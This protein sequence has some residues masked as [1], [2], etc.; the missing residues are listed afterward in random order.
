MKKTTLKTC[1]FLVILFLF[2]NLPPVKAQEKDTRETPKIAL[3]LSG[4]GAKGLAHIGV[5]KVL[6]EAGIRPDIITGTSMGSIVGALYAAGYTSDELT[7]INKNA[8]WDQLLTDKVK[9]LS[10]AMDEKQETKKYLF[11]IPVRDNKINLP[12]GLIEGQ[13][14]EAY[15]SELLWPLTS[16][17]NFNQLP[18]PFHCMSVDMISGET[19]EH[20]SGD[21]VQ[22]IRASMSIPTVFSP[23]KMDSLLLVDGGVT[24]NFPVQEAI[25]M[26]ADI[27]IGVY[28]GFQEDVTADEM[29]SMTDILQRSIA[30]AGIVDAKEQFPKCDVLIVPDLG[31]YSAGDFSN[32][33]IIQQLGEE[34]AR[35]K[36][37]E[38]K[39]LATKYNRTFQPLEKIDQPRKIK[40][41][42]FEVDGLQYLSKSYVLSKS[43]LEKGDSVSYKT[44]DEAIDFMY[45]SRHFGK[46]TYSLKEDPEND[47][48][49]LVFQVKENPRAMFKLAPNYDDDLGV[50]IVTNFTLRNMI[51]PATRMLLSFNIAE[52]PG[53]EIMLNKFVGKKQR[54]S[55]YFFASSYSYKL[56]FYDLGK[57]LGNYKRGYFEGGYGLE[58]LFG[59][60]NQIGG[61]AFY[62]YN[63]LTPRADLQSIYPEADFEYLKAHDWGYQ[64]YYKAN[65]TD[66]LYF[67][68]RGIKFN[69]RFQHVL[70]ANSHMK[71]KHFDERD[72]FVKAINEPYATLVLEHNWYK[73]FAKKFTY[74]FGVSGG[75]STE[76][77][78]SNG[79]F[80]LGGSQFGRNKLQFVDFAGFNFAEVYAYNF[81]FLKSAIDWEFATGVHFTA[82]ANVAATANTYEDLVEQIASNP[83]ENSIFG[84]SF[85]FKYES[86]L[87]PMQLMVSG[88]NQDDESRFHFSIGFPF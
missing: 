75:L 16:Q 48:Y 66:D 45:G 1:P 33:A 43:G 31:K 38:I 83:F 12:A 7:E 24:R 55:D 19:I 80:M 68:K 36:F 14:L 61:N 71:L 21:L 63:R 56:P 22:S 52:N 84:Y 6:E 26:G 2:L 81:A 47:G 28:V 39:K 82:I 51:A 53:M 58:Y 44:I 64:L 54:L 88:N 79:I 10:V 8:N 5:L 72:Y 32:G 62:K 46:L 25:D 65:T 59:L 30:L 60:N 4:G 40:I 3:V 67:P 41:T 37:T 15:F 29:T 77:S 50:G 13:H 69:I 42:D 17:T 87:G 70:S 23:M 74:N 76:E 57:R 35:E 78:A 85:G 86:L 34:A 20:S 18:I 73:T 49:I 27:I 9:L 11:E